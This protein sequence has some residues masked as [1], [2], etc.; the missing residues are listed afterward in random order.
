[1]F[2]K[3]IECPNC[4]YDQYD[5]LCDNHGFGFALEQFLVVHLM[6]KMLQHY[7]GFDLNGSGILLHKGF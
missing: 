6:D 7:L 5:V 1:M 2:E 4:Y 3:Y